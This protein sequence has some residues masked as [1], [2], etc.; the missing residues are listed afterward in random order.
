MELLGLIVFLHLIFLKD[1]FNVDLKK[2][3]LNLLWHCFCFML[4]D[5]WDISSL[6]KDRNHTP[7]TGSTLPKKV[8][9]VKAMVFPVGHIWMWELDHK[10]GWVLK[11]WC[12]WTVVL[13]ETLE[14]PLDFKEI[15]SVNLKDQ[16]WILIERI[17]PEAEA[18][19][20]WSP[21][22]KSW[23]IGKDPDAG[24]DQVQENRATED[25]MV[26]WHHQLKG[27]EFEQILGDGVKQGSLACCSPWNSKESDMT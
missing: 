2:S 16:P 20:L 3:L 18:P 5:M 19:I 17:D 21:D 15:K 4:W 13:E 25:E 8:H 24:K 7:W 6:I 23:L 11:N 9:M 12:F 14:S 27:H 26:G 1:H 10:E 22:V